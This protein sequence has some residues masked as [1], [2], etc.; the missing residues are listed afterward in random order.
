M[1]SASFQSSLSP[2]KP[3]TPHHP[4][5]VQVM[6]CFTAKPA[7]GGFRF[8]PL[9]SRAALRSA[10]FRSIPF[11]VIPQPRLPTQEC[12]HSFHSAQVQPTVSLRSPLAF[13][14]T[15]QNLKP[16]REAPFHPTQFA[17]LHSVNTLAFPNANQR[18]TLRYCSP[19]NPKC[20]KS[21]TALYRCRKK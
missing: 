14:P 6:Y 9:H 10:T 2:E 21:P 8:S 12:F 17:T 11:I 16:K 18:Y 15:S 4:S 19:L 1:R 7:A 20:H 13:Q 5:K 3:Q